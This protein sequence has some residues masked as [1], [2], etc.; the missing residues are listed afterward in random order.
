ML[1][2]AVKTG[3]KYTETK[4]KDADLESRCVF[5]A[6]LCKNWPIYLLVN[7]VFRRR[8]LLHE[9]PLCN[10]TVAKTFQ[11]DSDSIPT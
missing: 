1:N 3:K 7:G 5:M 10:K 11:I 6:H 8:R 9:T 2:V 4:P